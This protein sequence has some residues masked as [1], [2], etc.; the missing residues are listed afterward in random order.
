MDFVVPFLFTNMFV[1]GWVKVVV[2]FTKIQPTFCLLKKKSL[3]KR[4]R[5]SHLELQLYV[6]PS[7]STGLHLHLHLHL[8]L[9]CTRVVS[10]PE[11]DG[12]LRVPGGVGG[13]G[14]HPVGPRLGGGAW[15]RA[16]LPWCRGL[17]HCQ[18][19]DVVW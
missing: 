17:V 9:T 18:G 12:H 16:R 7:S 2:H 1:Q 19:S 13:G 5:H 8:H 10:P 6:R 3:K 14:E 11:L 4:G 15:C